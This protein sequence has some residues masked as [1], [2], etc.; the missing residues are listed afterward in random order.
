MEDEVSSNGVLA[1][2]PIVVAS[3][4]GTTGASD[5]ATAGHGRGD[6]SH[7]DADGLSTVLVCWHG[8]KLAVLCFVC[9]SFFLCG[10]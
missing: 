7:G 1:I 2:R 10:G 5:L 4:G 6:E 9:H 3:R 8:L